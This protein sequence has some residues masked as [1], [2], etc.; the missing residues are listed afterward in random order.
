[1]LYKSLEVEIKKV[2]EEKA[3]IDAIFSTADEDRHGDI[4]NQE[5]WILDEY[6]TNPVILWGHDHSQPAI[7]KA[8]DIG[9]D[10]NKN[11]S[12]TIQFAT[13]E[14]PFAK[15][16]YELYKGGFM[17]AFSVGYMNLEAEESKNGSP[18]H[19]VNRLFEISAVNVG[20]NALA[21]A[22]QKGID[23]TQLT[24]K[25]LDEMPKLDEVPQEIVETDETLP[26]KDD[27]IV[28]DA[29]QSNDNDET[30][31]KP[32]EVEIEKPN[33]TDEE[34][35]EFIEKEGR[36]LSKRN[37]DIINNAI[38]ALTEL[39]RVDNEEADSQDK[40]QRS[41]LQGNLDGKKAV[42]VFNKT[43]RVLIKEKNELKKVNKLKIKFD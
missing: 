43:I 23:V 12:G 22:K 15:V 4:V 2:D 34:I 21:L 42:K 31:S 24:S 20:A 8:V 14:N 30:I 39:V 18:V 37:K 7:G 33:A 27:L 5:G 19:K 29:T 11:L 10:E 40:N 3:T 28:P 16:I 41:K 1:M 36:V 9:L 6:K 25:D 13:K 17:R 38:N 35:K 26:K 32:T